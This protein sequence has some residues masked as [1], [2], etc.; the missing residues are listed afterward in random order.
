MDD[1][2]T[3]VAHLEE[4]VNAGSDETYFEKWNEDVIYFEPI[5][6]TAELLESAGFIKDGFHAYNLYL[7]TALQTAKTLLSFSG[8]YLYLRQEIN[9]RRFDDSVITLWNKD[10]MKVFYLQ[11]L[12]NLYYALTGT[13]LPITLK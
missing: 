2:L 8:D 9:D 3:T 11:Q 12:Q 1:F 5:P 7:P 6:L 4:R 10:V 13:E